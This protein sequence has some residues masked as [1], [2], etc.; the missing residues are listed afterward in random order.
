VTGSGAGQFE[1]G[2]V[3]LSVLTG[4]RKLRLRGFSMAQ[5]SGALS[6]CQ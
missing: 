1:G 6:G 3:Q 4:L 2:I 5:D